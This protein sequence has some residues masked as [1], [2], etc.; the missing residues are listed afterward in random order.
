MLL[1]SSQG[2]IDAL[3][4]LSGA[5]V[6]SL[7]NQS[8]F[9]LTFDADIPSSSAPAMLVSTPAAVK[10]EAP[11]DPTTISLSDSRPSHQRTKSFEDSPLTKFLQAHAVATPSKPPSFTKTPSLPKAGSFTSGETGYV[12]D[13]RSAAA[14]S[15]SNGFALPPATPVAPA[16]QPAPSP[17]TATSSETRSLKRSRSYLRI[18]MDDEGHA[19]LIDRAVKSP[20]PKKT[21]DLEARSSNLRRSHSAVGGDQSEISEL[22]SKKAP[23]TTAMGRSR[24]SRAWEFWCDSDARNSLASKADQEINGS[25]VDAIGQ[26]VASN[27]ALRAHSRR[28]MHMS[29]NRLSGG[30]QKSNRTPLSRS[31]TSNGR[32]QSMGFATPKLKD[33]NTKGKGV[34]EHLITDSDKENWTPTTEGTPFDSRRNSYFNAPSGAVDRQSPLRKGEFSRPGTAETLDENAVNSRS[35]DGTPDGEDPEIS[36][37]MRGG[38]NSRASSHS[39]TSSGEDL[40]CVQSLLTL[41]QGNWR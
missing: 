8:F 6:Q 12:A 7:P 41:S 29:G 19:E 27:K 35:K 26:I 21:A 30:F 2:D 5:D 16:A 40:E 25:A 3:H 39:A 37:F 4:A 13:R 32:L 38:G 24:D 36:H 22:F 31:R 9:D 17:A 11:E 33:I 34:E 18:T 1:P 14:R 10:S 20:S 15:I 23:R 28:S